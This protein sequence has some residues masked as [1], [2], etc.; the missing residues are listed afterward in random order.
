MR[1]PLGFILNDGVIVKREGFFAQLGIDDESGLSYIHYE[2][3]CTANALP[4]QFWDKSCEKLSDGSLR[5]I[6][7]GKEVD[8]MSPVYWQEAT[9][10]YATWM[11]PFV[12]YGMRTIQANGE[13]LREQVKEGKVPMRNHG[14]LWET[15]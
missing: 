7:P 12:S 3:I 9:D 8:L 13:Y 2:C 14:D 10:R 1:T 4:A 15:I 5:A 11:M 6:V